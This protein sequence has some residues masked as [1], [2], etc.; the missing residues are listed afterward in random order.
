MDYIHTSLQTVEVAM[1]EQRRIRLSKQRCCWLLMGCLLSKK[2]SRQEKSHHLNVLLMEDINER[3]LFV[4]QCMTLN[5]LYCGKL[6]GLILSIAPWTTSEI[7]GDN[8]SWSGSRPNR[9]LAMNVEVGAG[10]EDVENSSSSSSGGGGGGGGGGGPAVVVVTPLAAATA[11]LLVSDDTVFDSRHMC[12]PPV[13]SSS[14]S[15]LPPTR[16]PYVASID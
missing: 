5:Y 14:S 6:E 2:L 12:D 4:D 11:A 10:V 16:S 7:A 15:S 3:S 13:L 8:P 1:Y 9:I